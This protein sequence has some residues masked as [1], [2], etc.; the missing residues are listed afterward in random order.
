MRVMAATPGPSGR[1]TAA[2][3]A[4]VTRSPLEGYIGATARYGDAVRVRMGP[5]RDRFLLSRPARINRPG[6]ALAGHTE[7]PPAGPC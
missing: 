5:F 4:W 6:L 3:F 7:E 2:L 1:S